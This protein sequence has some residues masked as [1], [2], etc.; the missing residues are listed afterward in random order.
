MISAVKELPIEHQP[1]SVGVPSFH[2]SLRGF[3][4]FFPCL[5]DLRLPAMVCLRQLSWQA[6]QSV[7]ALRA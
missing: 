6:D 5:V 1:F 7:N 3:V 2:F 4:M